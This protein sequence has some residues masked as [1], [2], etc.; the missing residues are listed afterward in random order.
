MRPTLSGRARAE[1]AADLAVQYT[2]G[3]RIRQLAAATGRPYGTVR[4]LVLEG[5]ATLR[6]PGGPGPGMRPAPGAAERGGQAGRLREAG[7]TWREIAEQLGYTSP[8]AAHWAATRYYTPPAG[9]T[10]APPVSDDVAGTCT[11]CHGTGLADGLPC[12]CPVGIR[13]SNPGL[14]AE[15]ERAIADSAGDGCVR[16]SPGSER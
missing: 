5:G 10:V 14:R 9:G 12:P 4:A 8:G 2:D 11:A 3:K 6:G 13:M 1:L 15:Y 16:T 7:G